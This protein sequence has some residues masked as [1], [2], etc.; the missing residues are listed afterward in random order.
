MSGTTI[1]AGELLNTNPM[2]DSTYHLQVGSPC[3]DAG[4]LV[5]LPFNGARP[6]IG[7]FESAFAGPIPNTSP[8]GIVTGQ[9]TGQATPIRHG[10]R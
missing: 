10:F 3:I 7:A 4:C 1:G 8:L 5:G 2:M 6:D 9:V